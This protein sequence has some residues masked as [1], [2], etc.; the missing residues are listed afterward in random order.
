MYLVD[1]Y[2]TAEKSDLR[3]IVIRSVW[4]E[5][6]LDGIEAFSLML[7]MEPEVLA[8]EGDIVNSYSRAVRY[9]QTQTDR[10]A[11]ILGL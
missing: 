8:E 3:R 7:G 9:R 2:K 5:G 1:M 4:K 6:S 10:H 11:K